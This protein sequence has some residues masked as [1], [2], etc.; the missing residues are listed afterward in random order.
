M[1]ST[2]PVLLSKMRWTSLP[3]VDVDPNVEGLEG[4]RYR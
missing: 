2:R 1:I 4:C 3:D